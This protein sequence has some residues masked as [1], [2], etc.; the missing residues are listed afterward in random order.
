MT[1]V[2]YVVKPEFVLKKDSIFSGT[3]K[4]IEIPVSR[5]ID[6]DS[7]FDFN[8]AEFLFKKNLNDR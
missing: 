2:A 8:L 7:Q 6:I 4:S 3:V 5:S 1:T